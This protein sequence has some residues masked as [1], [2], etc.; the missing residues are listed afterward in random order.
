MIPS[1]KK[2]TE[3]SNQSQRIILHALLRLGSTPLC[4]KTPKHEKQ[5]KLQHASQTSEENERAYL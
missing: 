5:T 3:P 4:L 2:Q 1:H